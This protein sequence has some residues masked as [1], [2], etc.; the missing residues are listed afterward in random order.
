MASLLSTKSDT[1]QREI[2]TGLSSITNSP[3]TQSDSVVDWFGICN[4]L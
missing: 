4:V 1:I 3:A 2:D